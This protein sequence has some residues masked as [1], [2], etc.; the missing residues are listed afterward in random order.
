LEILARNV[1]IGA[2]HD[3]ITGTSKAHVHLDETLRFNN[4][5]DDLRLLM[6]ENLHKNLKIESIGSNGKYS[7][8]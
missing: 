3:A 8:L 7:Y 5:N 4:A 1:S 6:I 2:H